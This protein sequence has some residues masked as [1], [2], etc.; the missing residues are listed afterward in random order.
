[1][2]RLPLPAD[3]IKKLVV[4]Q[5]LIA[6]AKFDE[7]MEEAKRKNQSI[8]DILVSEKVVELDYLD[9]L[10]ATALGVPRVD[11][12]NRKLDPNLVKTLP[13]DVARQRQV[14]IFNKEDDG[15][16]DA[17]MVDPSDLETIEFLS[18]RLKANIKPFSRRR[19]DLNRGF[20]VYGYELGQDFKKLIEENIR[21]SL[22]NPIKERRG[23][24]ER[25]CRSSALWTIFFRT[26]SH[27]A[28]RTSISRSWR[29]LR[30][31]ATASTA[32]STR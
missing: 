7:Y 18:Q 5:G 25:S 8:I 23:G 2:P 22:L 3:Q 4:D 10:I 31:S 21:A 27:R 19:E 16:Y 9:T 20:S 15:T 30:S 14:I 29:S 24:G 32:F 1:M 13:E 6:D 17:A 11:F 12:N 26:R 28:R